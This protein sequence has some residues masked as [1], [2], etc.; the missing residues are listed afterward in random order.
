MDASAIA[1]TFLVFA[2]ALHILSISLAI[3]RCTRPST[4]WKRDE[5]A[6]PVSLV[7]PVCGV[8]QC[9]PM[10]LQSSFD[11]SYSGVEVI[12]CCASPGDPAAPLVSALIDR[13]PHIDAKLLIGEVGSTK[14]PKLNNLLKGWAAARHPWVIL[15]D[16]NVLLP[17]DYVEKL[18]TAWR[19]DTGLVCSPPV[20]CMPEGP[21]AE[22]ECAFLNS[23]QARWQL[24]AD[25]IGMGFAQGKSM[26]WRRDMLDDCG[27]LGALGLEI[28]EDA[29]ATKIVRGKG[30]RV[31]L[32]DRPFPQPLGYRTARQVWDRQVRWARLRRATF[33][34]YFVPEVLS[35][36]FPPLLATAWAAQGIGLD[37]GVLA[38]CLI[39]AWYLPE[40]L[41]TT[42]ARWQISKWSP[43][44][45]LARDL[46]IP[47][48]WFAA[49]LGN[50]FTWRGNDM[51]VADVQASG[52]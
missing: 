18:L 43:F 25:S 27:G 50:G 45:W 47:I 14:N 35:G 29:A 30:L 51:S 17:E 22:I 16:S 24:A 28:A 46:L 23:Y 3:F 21:W 33:V 32:V 37:P 48:I 52:S 1:L 41:L 6:P 8:D 2:F 36:I 20:G 34:L 4:V 19:D 49:W 38:T 13:S 5:A 11:L 26:L 7:R 40:A 42:V 39:A 12:F 44:A 15:A 10:T 31:R 9:D